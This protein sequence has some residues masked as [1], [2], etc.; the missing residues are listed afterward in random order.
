MAKKPAGKQTRPALRK[1]KVKPKPAKPTRKVG[2]KRA[3][4][5]GTSMGVAAA[6]GSLPIFI[7][8]AFT[9]RPFHGKPSVGVPNSPSVKV[10]TPKTSYP[11]PNTFP[12]PTP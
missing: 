7:V 10:P 1:V 11:T 12:A 2:R 3:P 8:D 9:K 4:L 6:S 5:R